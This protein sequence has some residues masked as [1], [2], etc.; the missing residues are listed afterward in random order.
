MTAI[1]KAKVVDSVKDSETH[2]SDISDVTARTKIER[3]PVNINLKG[4]EHTKA[5]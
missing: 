2:T 4:K 5:R 1:V 3:V